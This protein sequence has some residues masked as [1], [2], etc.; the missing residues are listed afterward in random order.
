MLDAGAKS[1]KADSIL[2]EKE[3]QVPRSTGKT[4]NLW[5]EFML[6]D[7]KLVPLINGVRLF[8]RKID[9]G[10]SQKQAV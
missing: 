8:N 3:D 9:S 5:A 1:A 2:A 10:Y 6:L 4:S 7:I